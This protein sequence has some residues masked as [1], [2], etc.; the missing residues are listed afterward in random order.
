MLFQLKKLKDKEI[1]CFKIFEVFNL[2]KNWFKVYNFEDENII[3]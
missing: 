1:K 2:I 3:Y